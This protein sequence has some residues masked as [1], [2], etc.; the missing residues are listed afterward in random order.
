[1][2]WFEQ[3]SGLNDSVAVVTAGAGGLGLAIVEDLRATGVRDPESGGDLTLCGE[4]PYNVR[5]APAPVAQWIEQLPSKQWVA[6]SSHA[7][8][9]LPA[10]SGTIFCSDV[11]E[12]E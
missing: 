10:I 4:R 8:G 9:V 7:G 12:V 1:M 3:R 5:D 6:C 11:E 2:S